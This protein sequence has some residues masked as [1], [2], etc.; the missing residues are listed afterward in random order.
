MLVGHSI[1]KV[2]RLPENP[3]KTIGKKF[4][5]KVIKNTHERTTLA[6]K[7]NVKTLAE[8]NVKARAVVSIV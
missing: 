6:G 2:G 4:M 1:V 3:I 7:G 5:I 8:G